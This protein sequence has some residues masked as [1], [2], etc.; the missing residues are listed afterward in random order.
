VSYKNRL[1]E[2]IGFMQKHKR[3]QLKQTLVKCEI[4]GWNGCGNWQLVI[5]HHIK[6]VAA[7]GQLS[8][9]NNI[10]FLC[11]NHH[12]IAH[13]LYPVRKGKYSGPTTKET[14]IRAIR[15]YETN[16]EEWGRKAQGEATQL[17]ANQ[18]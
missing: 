6:P 10:I 13:Y 3:Q 2:R 5:G 18:I 16:P 15:T 8:D 9:A 12:T 4:C 11:P 7:G 14:L 1:S 17:L